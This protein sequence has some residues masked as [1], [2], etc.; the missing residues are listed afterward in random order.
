MY[1]FWAHL[2]FCF[3]MIEDHNIAIMWVL[4]DRGTEFC[5]RIDK[6]PYQLYLQ[7]NNIEYTKT[8]VKSPRTTGICER[9]HQTVL[10]EFYRVTFRKKI[11]SALESLQ[12]DLDK[13]IDE[14]NNVRTHQGKRCQGR[15]PME[16]FIDGKRIYEEKDLD[17]H[18]AA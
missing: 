18:L 12:Q 5:G 11:Y 10:N 15:T 16:T 14:Y 3:L 2:L 17:E 1:I 9:F 7:L 8:K 6:H 13:F 4:T